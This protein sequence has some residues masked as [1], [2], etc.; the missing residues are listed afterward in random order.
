M[1]NDQKQKVLQEMLYLWRKTR[2][3]RNGEDGRWMA[4][5]CLFRLAQTVYADEEW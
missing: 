1:R 2:A 3:K 5:F 4:V